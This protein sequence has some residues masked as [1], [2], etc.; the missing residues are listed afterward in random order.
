MQK[1][2]IK[3]PIDANTQK[4]LADIEALVNMPDLLDISHM[5][6]GGW[7]AYV[8]SFESM[9]NKALLNR[10]ITGIELKG[11]DRS[12]SDG[13]QLFNFLNHECFISGEKKDLD[14]LEDMYT[15]I[16]NGFSIILIECYPKAIKIGTQGFPTRA[17]SEPTANNFVKGSKEAFTESV[18]QNESMVRRRIKSNDLRMREMFIGRESETRCTVV[19]L[20]SRVSK[21]VLREVEKLFRRNDLDMVFETGVFEILLQGKQQF[22]FS[23]IHTT[24]RP[25][26]LCMRIYEGRVGI[27]VDGTPFVLIIP[28]LFGDNFQMLDDYNYKAVFVNLLRIIRVFA[29][30]IAIFLPAVYIA[31]C[32]FTPD[33]LTPMLVQTFLIAQSANPFP[34]MY[35][36]LVVTLLYELMREAGLRLPKEVGH[37]ITIVGSIIIG[38]AAINGSFL[39]PPVVLIA[40]IVSIATYL[41]PTLIDTIVI[42]R[43]ASIFAAGYFGF[44]GI[45]VIA[46]IAFIALVTKK[47][48]GVRYISTIF[49]VFKHFRQSFAS[50][51]I[52]PLGRR[53]RR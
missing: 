36:M 35:E 13:L 4:A 6:I 38:E 27:M 28:Y 22:L 43:I 47:N 3:T 30:I 50:S 45:G 53:G 14:N 2:Q 48:M 40:A 1:K 23:H 34:L 29:F 46:L 49:P 16:V 33:L 51:E 52:T 25:D 32:N 5:K 31:F 44:W 19:Y 41:I 39:S 42:L 21:R 24:D 18:K 37:T 20:E 11:L 26:M 15:S 12:F 9:I 10:C 7:G 17:I 8:I